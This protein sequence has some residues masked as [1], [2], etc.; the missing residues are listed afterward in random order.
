[1]HGHLSLLAAWHE[2]ISDKNPMLNPATAPTPPQPLTI[3]DLVVDSFPTQDGLR[4]FYFLC[5][6]IRLADVLNAV[7][8]RM[9]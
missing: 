5:W 8:R 4:A 3:V 1:M 2:Y 9:R 6:P 7:K